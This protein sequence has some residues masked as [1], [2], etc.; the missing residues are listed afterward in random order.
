MFTGKLYFAAAIVCGTL[1]VNSPAHAADPAWPTKPVKVVVPFSAG[2]GTDLL[3]RLIAERLQTVFGQPFVVDNRPGAGGNI[4]TDHVAKQAPDGYTL[5]VTTNTHAMNAAFYKRL[6]YDPVK[7]FAPVSLVATSPLVMAV[8][9]TLPVKT[10]NEFI[11]LAKSK[12]G[13]LSYGTTGNG[14]P[15]QLAPSML[16]AA[17]GIRMI[18]VPYKGA[19]PV[20]TALLGNEVTT[21]VGAVNSIL[22]HVRTGKLRLL[23]VADESRSKLL[24][25]VPTIAEAIPLPRFSVELWY[26]VFAPAGTPRYIVD[27]LN[28]EI[29]KLVTNPD[30]QKNRL[31]PSGME[32]VGTTSAALLE[33]VKKDVPKYI[34]AARDANITME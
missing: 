2:G 3:G 12:P 26:A 6:P 33:V 14:T 22:P 15:Q 23:A 32:G 20:V 8:N 19:A 31:A 9:A 17:T 28:T 34:K 5:L 24:P 16:E 29:N 4:G 18:H 7:D 21:A 10:L 11:S 25:D 30:I 13:E 27:R 1:S